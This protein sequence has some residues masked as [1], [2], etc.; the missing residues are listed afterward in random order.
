MLMKDGGSRFLRSFEPRHQHLNRILF[1]TPAD[2]LKVK[3]GQSDL[4][5]PVF[6][7]LNFQSTCVASA[8]VRE[9]TV[10]ARL[11]TCS[12]GKIELFQSE[13]KKL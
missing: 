12:F 7:S 5:L 3:I 6:K 2:G 8:N 9:C 13:E 1:V 4:A 10:K 11:L